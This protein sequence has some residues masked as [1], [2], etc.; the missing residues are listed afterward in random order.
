MNFEEAAKAGK[1]LREIHT[2][3]AAEAKLDA[4]LHV[5]WGEENDV[6]YVNGST[7]RTCFRMNLRYEE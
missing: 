7:E 2:E 4:V 5:A 3:Y 1:L 6:Y